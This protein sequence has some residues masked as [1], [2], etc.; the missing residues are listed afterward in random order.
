V[1]AHPATRE[2]VDPEELEGQLDDQQQHQQVEVGPDRAQQD[3]D[4]Q[5]HRDV[6]CGHHEP[7]P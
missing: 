6:L 3:D 4:R 7:T 2:R 1:L 5:G